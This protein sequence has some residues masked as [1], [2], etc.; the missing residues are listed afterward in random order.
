M[1]HNS[2]AQFQTRHAD[3]A[4]VLFVVAIMAAAI[5]FLFILLSVLNTTPQVFAIRPAG[6]DWL[7]QDT[8]VVVAPSALSRLSWGA[9]I[10]GAVIALIIQLALNLLGLSV[11]ITTLT[12]D[13]N[14]PSPQAGEVA[15]GV[16]IW[17]GISSLASLFL[18]GWIAARFAGIPDNVDGMLHGLMVWGVVT[19]ISFFLLTT[20]IGRM[21]SGVS[22]L[23]SRVL[24]MLG[25]TAQ[26]IAQGVS[27]V[28]QGVGHMAQ[29]AA[30]NV[31]QAAQGAANSLE[32]TVQ[33]AINGNPEVVEAVERLD[34]SFEGIMNEAQ[35]LLRQVGISP[36]RVQAQASNAVG[37]AQAAVQDI[38]RDPVHFD[39]TLNL[40][41]RRIFRRGQ[42]VVSDVDR[43]TALQLLMER[44]QMTEEHAQQM[45][46]KWEESWK[47]AQFELEKA[48]ARAEQEA[49]RLQQEL[50]QKAEEARVQAEH[51]AREAAKATTQA[52]AKIAG[53][54]FL[55]ILVGAIAAG[56]GGMI[57]APES[58]PAADVDTTTLFHST[59]QY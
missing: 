47:G 11:G 16:L 3:R 58:V 38:V 32:S 56:L 19:L 14:D 21:V 51:A 20:T 12:P 49:K 46:G 28:A 24:N 44:G 2:S 31:G 45:L 13:N 59:A 25:Q 4:R 37:D 54:V 42:S 48:R 34:L 43:N 6:A 23:I 26:G 5:G 35:S 27:N 1:F 10:A 17:A 22:A 33:D 57:G 15:T 55:A 52:V 29:D 7:M 30:Q 53:A 9:V 18:G 50:M 41:L 40:A 36:Q 39:Q 8:D